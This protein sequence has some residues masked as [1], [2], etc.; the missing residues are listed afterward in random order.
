MLRIDPIVVAL[1]R[2]DGAASSTLVGACRLPDRDDSVFLSV[3]LVP[4]G[5]A[6]VEQERHAAT[7]LLTQDGLC[8]AAQ[9]LSVD[10]GGA[11]RQLRLV[12]LAGLSGVRTEIAR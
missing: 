6:P 1:V 8:A 11:V 9:R 12:R 10:H 5:L 4:D 3:T 7:G 2:R